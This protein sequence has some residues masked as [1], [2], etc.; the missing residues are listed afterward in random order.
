MR[1]SWGL[2]LLIRFAKLFQVVPL[3]HIKSGHS[4]N[5][6][7]RTINEKF[8]GGRLKPF[9]GTKTRPFKSAI[10][11]T[12]TQSSRAA[13]G[14]ISHSHRLFIDSSRA[15]LLSPGLSWA[16]A[17]SWTFPAFSYCY[18]PLRW[19]HGLVGVTCRNQA[20]QK[21]LFIFERAL[22]MVR[23]QAVTCNVASVHTCKRTC[24]C[25]ALVAQRRSV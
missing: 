6:S 18:P 23:G 8:G 9:R 12:R 15:V 16:C 17:L 14:I 25:G 10:S 4:S 2:Q 20:S 24:Q 5:K 19:H 1:I 7:S 21:H 3:P 22:R 13:P 11:A